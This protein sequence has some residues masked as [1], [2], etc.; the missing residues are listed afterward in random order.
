MMECEVCYYRLGPS[1]RYQ[2]ITTKQG[3]II[4]KIKYRCNAHLI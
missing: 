4:E 1:D 2:Q 3:E